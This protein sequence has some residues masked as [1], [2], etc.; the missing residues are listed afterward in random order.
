MNSFHPVSE[1]TSRCAG[2]SSVLKFSAC[3][4]KISSVDFE[5]QA[6][7]AKPR[8]IVLRFFFSF[9]G[10]LQVFVGNT[11]ENTIVYNELNGSIVARYTRF[12]PT[13]WH[14]HISMRVELYGCKGTFFLVTSFFCGIR[15]KYKQILAWFITFGGLYYFTA[16]INIYIYRHGVSW[17]LKKPIEETFNSDTLTSAWLHRMPK[18]EKKEF[19]THVVPVH[20]GDP[21]GKQQTITN[22]QK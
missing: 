16:N 13:A 12:Q 4:H 2:T 11:D 15:K 3:R 21:L 17:P 22:K 5:W 19:M 8:L 1:V 7:G 18:I 14:N 9:S 20:C 6:N 10:L